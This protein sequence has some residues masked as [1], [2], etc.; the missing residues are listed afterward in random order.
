MQLNLNAT[1]AKGE[2]NPKQIEK[3][4][5]LHHEYTHAIIAYVGNS[6]ADKLNTKIYDLIVRF[7]AIVLNWNQD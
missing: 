7:N 6:D 2:L 3:A 5:H 4:I 1:I